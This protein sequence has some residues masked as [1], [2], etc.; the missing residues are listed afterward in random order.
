MYMYIYHY[1]LYRVIFFYIYTVIER[2]FWLVRLVVPR[3]AAELFGHAH[4]DRRPAE[5]PALLVAALGA[6]LSLVRHIMYY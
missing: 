6:G 5:R 1:I 2:S 4:H 3:P